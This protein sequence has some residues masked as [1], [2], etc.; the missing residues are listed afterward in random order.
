MR[1]DVKITCGYHEYFGWW[2]VRV[3]H[4]IPNGSAINAHAAT[5]P[6]ALEKLAF[7]IRET[8]LDDP[9]WKESAKPQ[10]VPTPEYSAQSSAQH[11]SPLDA[12]DPLHRSF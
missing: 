3:N 9:I 6:E 4:D 11:H 12:P 10:P 2:W 5:L 1:D 8:G 7:R